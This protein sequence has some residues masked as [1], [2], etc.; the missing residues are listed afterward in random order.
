MLFSIYSPFD[1]LIF[2]QGLSSMTVLLAT[3]SVDTSELLNAGD[4]DGDKLNWTGSAVL[5]FRSMTSVIRPGLMILSLTAHSPFNILA[6]IDMEGLIL[7]LSWVHRSPIFSN[8]R[9]SSVS[10][11]HLRVLSMMLSRSSDS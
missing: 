6:T 11:S 7:G 10:K 5:T 9:A 8:L 3:A 4:M 1:L 2:C